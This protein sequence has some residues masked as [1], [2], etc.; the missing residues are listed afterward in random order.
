MLYYKCRAK[1][2]FSI[3]HRLLIFIIGKDKTNNEKGSLINDIIEIEK[4]NFYYKP[5]QQV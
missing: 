1:S 5:M 2:A 4:F 3:T